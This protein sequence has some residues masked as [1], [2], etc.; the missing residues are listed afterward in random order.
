MRVAFSFYGPSP[1]GGPATWVRRM[2]PRLARR[3]LDVVAIPFQ[4]ATGDC[5]VAA[6]LREAGVAVHEV[7]AAGLPEADGLHRMLQTLAGLRPDVI[8]ADHVIPAF[9]GGRWAAAHGV[10]TVMV[11][12]GNDRWYHQLVDTFVDRRNRWHVAAVVAVSAELQRLAARVAPP[13]VEMMRCPSGTPIP[14]RVA[15]WRGEPFHAV[16]AGRLEAAEKRAD[17]VVR[18]LIATSRA[19]PAFSASIIGDGSLRPAIE[20]LLAREPGHR[21]SCRGR[22]APEVVLREL[23]DAQA[24]VLLSSSEGLS[25]AVQEAMAS[26]VPV[27]ARR[28]ESGTDGVLVH[29]ETALLIE[30]DARLT[31]AALR[32][33]E[34]ETLWQRLSAGGRALAEREFDIERAADRWR[35]L[36]VRLGARPRWPQVAPPTAADAERLWADY[37]Q[38]LPDLAAHQALFLLQRGRLSRASLVRLLDSDTDWDGRRCV[39]HAAA[40]AGVLA[41][42]DVVA[43]ARGLAA[44]VAGDASDDVRYRR[45]A[46]YRLAGDRAAASEILTGL[47]ASAFTPQVRAGSLFHLADAARG[48]GRLDDAMA[49]ARECLALEPGHRAAM[50]LSRDIMVSSVIHG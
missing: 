14:E 48:E 11:L 30:D 29:G 33:L 15:R 16:Y 40:R 43:Y 3:G 7:E 4:T 6:D 45:A 2:L 26:G 21:V 32:L 46:L 47:A 50:T 25:S 19:I 44:E 8:V 34:S 37:L 13:R 24:L 39:F 20:Q 28:T 27:V 36:L 22:L 41:P 17:D 23:L 18:A 31:D 49:L 10:P 42:L 9:L 35:S 5:S 38:G 1:L 12:R